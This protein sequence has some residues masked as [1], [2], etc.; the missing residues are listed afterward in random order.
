MTPAASRV[1]EPAPRADMHRRPWPRAILVATAE[2]APQARAM[3]EAAPGAG[4]LLGC[5]LIDA[6]GADTL[7]LLGTLDDLDS[8]KRAFGPTMAIVCLPASMGE[9]IGQVRAR[10]RDTGIAERFIPPVED[11]LAHAP[12]LA[13]GVGVTDSAHYVPTPRID[14]GALIGRHPRAIDEAS[15]A[16]VIRA[17]RVLITGAGGSIGAELARIAARFEPESLILV[18]RSENALF[19]IDRQLSQRFPRVGRLAMLHDVVDADATM[20]RLAELKPDVVFHAAAHKHVPLMEDHPAHAVRNNLLG[21]KSIA[22][23]ALACACERFVM[24]STDKAV[25]PTSVMGATKRLAELYVQHLHRAARTMGGPVESGTRYAIVRFGNVLGSACSVLTI[26]SAQIAE[27]QPITVTD[28]RMT[29]YF[30]TIPEAAA[31]VMQAAAIDAPN[32]DGS[33]AGLY[34]LDMGEP[35][36][37]LDLAERFI[38]AHGLAPRVVSGAGAADTGSLP[39][40]D[41][42]VTGIRPGEKIHE[43]LAYAN[44]PLQPTGFEAINAWPGGLPDDVDV[45]TMIEDLTRAAGS[46]DV[47]EAI[48]RHVPQ[49]RRGL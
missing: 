37:I 42:I 1:L 45:P 26:W 44:E 38:R 47:L 14:L 46:A 49:M 9:L 27:G 17:R 8:I 10:L 7:D 15:V 29:R 24:I 25:N 3:L 34:V 36:R 11:L 18:E 6:R 28:E 31:L 12:P 20:R 43:E 19:E 30:M 22:D 21:T 35:I 5:I 4:D 16:R 33:A 2:T 13:I 39:S 48:R 23:A 32:S 41:V 40:V